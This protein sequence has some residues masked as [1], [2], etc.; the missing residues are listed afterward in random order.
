MKQLGS[1]DLW[2]TDLK[3]RDLWLLVYL[4]N[5]EYVSLGNHD[6]MPPLNSELITQLLLDCPRLKRVWLDGI[7][8]EPTQKKA[9]EAK[10]DSLRITLP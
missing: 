3:E 5:L 7:N 10:L 6:E 9:L 1:L 2:A 8:L 4:P